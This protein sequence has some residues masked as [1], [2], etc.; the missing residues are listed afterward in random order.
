MSSLRK[1]CHECAMPLSVGVANCSNCGATVGTLFSET[2]GPVVGAK[3]K[4]QSG[5]TQKVDHHYSI[6]KA[7][8]RANNSVILALTSFFPFIGLIMGVAAIALAAMAARTLKAAYVEDGRG[9]ATAGLVIGVLGLIAQGGY[10]VYVIKS[11][12]P[13]G[14]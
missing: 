7:Q 5:I 4:R 9:S 12:T 3:T 8:E 13:F 14:G 1:T 2:G 10:V 11:G 6:E